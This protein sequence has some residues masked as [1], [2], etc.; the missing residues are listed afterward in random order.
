MKIIPTQY[1]SV[2]YRSRT[3]ARWAVFFDVLGVGVEYEPEGYILNGVPYLVDFWIPEWEL[4][5]EVKGAEPT[6]AEREKCRLL[7]RTT[8]QPV[9]C[10]YGG[11][12]ELA[13]KGVLFT[14]E[15]TIPGVDFALLMG[16]RRCER[17][18]LGSMDEAGEV[19]SWVALGED[20]FRV[21]CADRHPIIDG[22]RIE[23]AYNKARAER[24]TSKRATG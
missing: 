6:E 24:F 12:H 17:V 23:E 14:L 18:V 8:K 13:R 19:W 15:D 16:C 11:M 2:L 20:C 9:L 5:V 21:C 4:F 3:E 10:V 1:K 7:N 22:H